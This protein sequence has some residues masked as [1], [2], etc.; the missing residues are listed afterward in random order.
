MASWSLDTAHS[1][2]GFSVRHM[3]FAK[4]RGQ[5][6]AWSGTVLADDEGRL[7]S[8]AADI[9]VESIDTREAQRDA[10]L[11]SPDFFDAASHP[12]MTFRSTAIR[13]D[14]ARDF[15]V[16]GDLTI[17]GVTRPVT[18]NVEV[19]GGGKDPW[20][21]LR[22]GYRATTRIDRHAFGLNWNQALELGGVLVGEHVDIEIEA[23]AVK[24]A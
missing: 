19:T 20:G 7:S 6:R 9:D 18:L 16:D 4:V 13:G 8:L 22:R 23:Q 14:T 5:F 21:N 24:A 1:E 10:H 17:R 2:V 15:E 12:K 3:M 11:R